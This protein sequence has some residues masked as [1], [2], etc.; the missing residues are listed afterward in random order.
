[1]KSKLSIVLDFPEPFG[2]TTAVKRLWK[3]PITYL[4]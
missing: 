1:M 2:P 3:G 4:P